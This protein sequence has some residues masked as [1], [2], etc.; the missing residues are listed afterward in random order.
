MKRS[1]AWVP[2]LGLLLLAV[3]GCAGDNESH[4][5]TIATEVAADDHASVDTPFPTLLTTGV[6]VD[7]QLVRWAGSLR[8]ED[9]DQRQI[10]IDG[11]LCTLLEKFD[12]DLEPSGDPLQIDSPCVVLRDCRIQS[13]V[14]VSNEGAMVQQMAGNDLLVVDRCTFDGGASHARGI[15]AGPGDLIVRRSS[16]VRFGNAGVEFGD[17]SGQRR[18]EVVDSYFEETGGWNPEDHV[19]GIQVGCGGDVR[20]VHNTVLVSPYGDD[21][22]DPAYGST[23][24][25]GL[26]AELGDITGDVDIEGNL[27]GGGAFVLYLETR[28]GFRFDGTVTVTGNT[29][30]MRYSDLGGIWGILATSTDSLELRWT[31]NRFSDGETA[32]ATPTGR[33]D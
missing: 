4:A 25:V 30:D 24:A 20:I 16:F 17:E 29:F 22:K 7:V 15:L 10:E 31:A 19:D 11:H 27:L 26:W 8:A 18:L 21:S 6:G 3:T 28:G 5:S 2:A 33:P 9:H 32:L 14:P 12:L 13:E 23:S 1:T